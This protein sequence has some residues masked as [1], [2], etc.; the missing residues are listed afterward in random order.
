MTPN[1]TPNPV[2]YTPQTDE[3]SGM[4][5]AHAGEYVS[6]TDYAIERSSRIKLHQH[7][8]HIQEIVL[9]ALSELRTLNP[10][11]PSP[12]EGSIPGTPSPN[13]RETFFP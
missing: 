8:N 2:R 12:P 1:N 5:P 13:Q 6:Y 9:Y 7:L 11:V 10:N 3:L 4:L